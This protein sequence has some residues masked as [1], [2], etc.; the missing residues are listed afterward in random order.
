MFSLFSDGVGPESG[1][2]RS[3][4][5]TPRKEVL[6]GDAPRANDDLVRGLPDAEAVRSQGSVDPGDAFVVV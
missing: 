6:L 1:A 2:L 5:D 3:W 4:A